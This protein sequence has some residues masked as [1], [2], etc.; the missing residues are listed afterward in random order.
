MEKA[1]PAFAGREIWRQD[2][3]FGFPARLTPIPQILFR[4]QGFSSP[5]PVRTAFAPPRIFARNLTVHGMGWYSLQC[6]WPVRSPEA[7]A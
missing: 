6:L 5:N 3:H 2:T 1:P 4:R 7:I